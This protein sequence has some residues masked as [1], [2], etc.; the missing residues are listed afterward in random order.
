MNKNT[1][2]NFNLLIK[3]STST[4]SSEELTKTIIKE[5]AEVSKEINEQKD[6]VQLWQEQNVL[7]TVMNNTLDSAEEGAFDTNA[8]IK[9]GSSFST[10]SSAPSKFNASIGGGVADTTERTT[11]SSF[12]SVN[13]TLP[14]SEAENGIMNTSTNQIYN[15]IDTNQMLTFPQTD[16]N[17]PS[18]EIVKA[19]IKKKLDQAKEA[20]DV[21]AI[22]YWTRISNAF[23]KDAVVADFYNKPD[24]MLFTEMY[25]ALKQSRSSLEI[26]NFNWESVRKRMIEA[27]DANILKGEISKENKNRWETIKKQLIDDKTNIANLFEQYDELFL[28]L[29]EVEGLE[30]LPNSITIRTKTKVYPNLSADKTYPSIG[31]EDVYVFLKKISKQEV[32]GSGVNKGAVKIKNT[33][34]TSFIVG[35]SLEFFLDE[36]LLNQNSKK[37]EDINWVVYKDGKKLG[38]EFINEGTSFSYN[39]DKPGAY[40]I[41]A[42]GE[43]AGANKK[44]KANESGFVKVNIIA[45]EIQISALSGAKGE[46]VRPFTEEKMFKVSLKNTTVKTLNPLKL[47]YQIETA[48]TGKTNVITEERELDPSG[49]IKLAMPDSGTYKI[50]VVSK[51]QYGL[52]KESKTSVIKN[53]VMSIGLAAEETNSIF[54]SGIP[55]QKI[56]LEA[57]TFKIN[58]ATDEEKEDVRWMI[59]DSNNK[60]YLVS[61][62]D[63]ITEGRDPKKSYL[64]K[65]KEF[66]IPIPQKQG[67]YTVEAFSNRQKG[68]QSGATFKIEVKQPEITEAYWTWRGGSKKTSSGFSGENNYIKALIPRYENQKVRVYFYLD[69]V[70]TNHYIDVKTNAKGEIFN[71]IKFDAS[72]QNAIG[73]QNRK[74]AKIGFKLLGIQNSKPYPFKSSANYEADTTLSVTT[75]KKIVDIYFTYGGV[76][77]GKEN[78]VPFGKNGATVTIVAK[79]QN[80]VGDEIELKAHKREKSPSFIGKARVESEGVATTSFLLKNLDK[81]LKIGTKIEYYAGV[82]GYPTKHLDHKNKVLVMIVGEGKVS[83]KFDENDPQLVW[84]AKVSKE[85]RVKVVKICKE[86]WPNNTLEMANGL[87]AVM[88]RET[89]DTFAPHRI[90]GKKLIPKEQLTK[91]SFNSYDEKG[92]RSSLAVGLIQFTQKA[93]TDM[94]DYKGGGFDELH[95]LKLKYANMTQLEQLE[96]VKKYMKTVATLPTKPEDIYLAVFA[97]AFVGKK[98]DDTMY[99]LGTRAYNKNASLDVD[100][101]K[102][103]IQLKELLDAYYENY[104]NGKY[105]RNIWHNP[106]D[107]MELRGWYSTWRPEDS[108]HGVIPTRNTGKHDGLDLYA[109]VETPVFACV[110]GVRVEVGP[111]PSTTYGNTVTIMGYYSGKLYYFFYAHL[112]KVFIEIGEKVQAGKIIGQTGKTGSTASSLLP[113]QCHLHFEVRKSSAS[114][115][116]AIDPF[117][118]ITELKNINMNPNPENQK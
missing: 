100:T 89:G 32:L 83:D 104:N 33:N 57:K 40:I 84:G 50:K 1:I 80:M 39:F 48:I 62:N 11:T 92:N 68:V 28:L 6:I 111:S 5:L 78:E 65:W 34:A 61:Q 118:V 71:K 46:F 53:E 97:P 19:E 116:A 51:D 23:E 56:T 43:K 113:K 3:N 17:E 20:N 38:T 63:L 98:L 7:N 95:T 25:T 29:K 44:A 22:Q 70:K 76:R 14:V 60:P 64:H 58:P 31:T 101:T 10:T 45:Q 108:K 86:L 27:I 2:H 72:F 117:N 66:S 107:K 49:I 99:E 91:D 36:S 24:E 67:Y 110:D 102:N 115:G 105:T 21:E 30:A 59:Y 42:Y 47:Y 114:Q 12:A 54:L 74:N 90:E 81:K 15:S 69:N 112:S 4:Q 73:F 87:M 94:G 75:E 93:L 106:L 96:K 8:A 16:N 37:K 35:E 79:T 88:N 26:K 9:T 52:F 41:E 13:T 103:G 109:T 77:V 85:F 55:N 82:E 18:V